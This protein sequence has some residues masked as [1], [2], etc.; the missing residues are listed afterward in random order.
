MVRCHHL[1]PR[2]KLNTGGVASAM[3]KCL[4][5]LEEKEL[6]EFY[7]NKTKGKEGTESYCKKCSVRRST[8]RYNRKKTSPE[9]RS[10]R[11]E[12][13][14]NRSSKQRRSGERREYYIVRDTKGSDRKKGRENN[15][16]QKFVATLVSQPC[17]Y[18]GDTET[19]M[20]VD[21]IDNSIGHLETNVVPACIRCN[22][23]R[24][25]MP[26]EAWEIVA[27]GMREAFECGLF[28]SWTGDIRRKK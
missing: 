1:P 14:K 9:Y 11:N 7:R 26:Y 15:L 3:K 4:D 20:T 13:E 2:R 19:R 6:S 16:T 22:L 8:D 10:R 25:Q 17:S 24:G 12:Y 23:V 18:C 27:K 21:R 5:C 28:S